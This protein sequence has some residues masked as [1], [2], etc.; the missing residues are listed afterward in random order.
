MSFSP[1]KHTVTKE[2]V[3]EV[4]YVQY[5]S[6]DYIF[7]LGKGKY[8]VFSPCTVLIESFSLILTFFVSGN[9]V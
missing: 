1:C 9:A 5:T 7:I 6:K 4:M 2:I 3:N 8:D